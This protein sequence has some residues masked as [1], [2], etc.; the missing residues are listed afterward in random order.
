MKLINLSSALVLGVALSTFATNVMGQR[1]NQ[2][3]VEAGV[4][5]M[6]AETDIKFKEDTRSASRTFTKIDDTIGMKDSEL[7]QSWYFLDYKEGENGIYVEYLDWDQDG[8]FTTGRKSFGSSS[9]SGSIKS[10]YELKILQA[11]FYESNDMGDFGVGFVGVRQE[12]T[13]SN[14]NS[15]KEKLDRPMAA[16]KWRQGSD[17]A[18]DFYY[19]LSA[20]YMGWLDEARGYDVMAEAGYKYTFTD[21]HNRPSNDFIRLGVGYRKFNVKADVDRGEF[22]LDISG[23]Y[24]RLALGTSF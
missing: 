12:L 8:S 4:I 17:L 10:V 1:H 18:E 6:Q 20:M 2:G 15:L 16:F 22:K 3:H 21:Q 5:Y 7:D 13:L 9:V 19:K 24:A 11:M 14:V 23:G